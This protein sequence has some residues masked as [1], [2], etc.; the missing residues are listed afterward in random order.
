MD[1]ENPVVRWSERKRTQ[2]IEKHKRDRTII[3]N[4]DHFL[5]QRKYIGKESGKQNTFRV[6]LEHEDRCY[7]VVIGRDRL[8][9]IN[10]VTVFGSSK[11]SFRRNRLRGMEG[12]QE[13]EK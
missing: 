11:S 8:G 1:L 13:R 5:A 10:I 6:L 3:L 7:T 2:V 9:E 4:I 12:T